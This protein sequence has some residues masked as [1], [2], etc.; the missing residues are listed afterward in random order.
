MGHCVVTKVLRVEC[1][2]TGKRKAIRRV[3][4]RETGVTQ[5]HEGPL[6]GPRTSQY[7]IVLRGL[8]GALNYPPLCRYPPVSRSLIFVVSPVSGLVSFK[9]YSRGVLA[10]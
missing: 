5:H 2:Q 8:R 1:S 7:S 3:A 6:L 10:S 4:V 9:R